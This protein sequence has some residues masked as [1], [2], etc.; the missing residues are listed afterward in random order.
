[1]PVIVYRVAN[2]KDALG[3]YKSSHTGN[4]LDLMLDNHDH[5]SGRPGVGNDVIQKRMQDKYKT[6]K[7]QGAIITPK[8]LFGFTSKRELKKWFNA[9]ERK[10]LAKDEFHV[11]RLKVSKKDPLLLRFKKQTLFD[12]TSAQPIDTIDILRI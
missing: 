12:G 7:Q 10:E 2:K 8:T 9:E 3:P 4:K 5:R 1:M 6:R 11:V